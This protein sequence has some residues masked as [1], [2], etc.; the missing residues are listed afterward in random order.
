MDYLRSGRLVVSDNSLLE[1]LWLAAAG[2]LNPRPD[3][4]I[5]VA[6]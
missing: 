6:P 5:E 1:G 2:L 3:K 4:L